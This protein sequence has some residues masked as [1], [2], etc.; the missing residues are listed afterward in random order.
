M[1]K[2]LTE[3]GV[4]GVHADKMKL[5]IENKTQVIT[6]TVIGVTGLRH[7]STNKFF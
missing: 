1:I 6:S 5:Q 7:L 2:G 4:F 3:A